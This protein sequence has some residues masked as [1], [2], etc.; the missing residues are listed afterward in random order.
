MYHGSSVVAQNV[1]SM[2]DCQSS[3]HFEGALLSVGGMM[4]PQRSPVTNLLLAGGHAGF[5]S[6]SRASTPAGYQPG[7]RTP[8]PNLMS[9]QGWFLICPAEG[10]CFREIFGVCQKDWFVWVKLLS[11]YLREVLFGICPMLA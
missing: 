10:R 8:T 9:P 3:T 7:S 1:S 6:S 4:A 11:I 5:N 2:K